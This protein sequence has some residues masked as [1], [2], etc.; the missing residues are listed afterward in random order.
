MFMGSSHRLRQ[1]ITFPFGQTQI[2]E[3]SMSNRRFVK[4][5]VLIGLSNQ[6][7]DLSLNIRIFDE[8]VM[9]NRVG[10]RVGPISRHKSNRDFS[11]PVVFEH[12]ALF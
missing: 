12:R 5:Y 7:C 6:I 4:P 2:F 8:P 10:N 11:D 3:Y 9:V 1:G